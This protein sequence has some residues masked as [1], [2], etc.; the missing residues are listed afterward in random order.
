MGNRTFYLDLLTSLK[1]PPSLDSVNVV[2][3]EP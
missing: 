3:E 2:R 1:R